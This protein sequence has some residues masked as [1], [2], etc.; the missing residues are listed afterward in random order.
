M[1][2]LINRP[3]VFEKRNNNN[4]RKNLASGYQRCTTIVCGYEARR[5]R[6]GTTPP[7]NTLWSDPIDTGAGF[8]KTRSIVNHIIHTLTHTNIC[9]T[10]SLRV[11]TH[12]LW[13]RVSDGLYRHAQLQYANY[14]NIIRLSVPACI[15]AYR[16]ISLS[17]L[18]SI[19]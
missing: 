7:G 10:L 8:G 1:L 19:F 3:I 6:G 15:R 11:G 13:V 2:L 9:Y 5:K 14:N 4:D 12:K 18:G 16:I 17:R